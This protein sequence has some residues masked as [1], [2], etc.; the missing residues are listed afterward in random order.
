[1]AEEPTPCP[2]PTGTSNRSFAD[3]R[4]TII[5]DVVLAGV[6]AVVM[7]LLSVHFEL[8]A[9]LVSFVYANEKWELD[10]LFVVGCYSLAAAVVFF[11]RRYREMY[12]LAH[13]RDRA[14]RAVEQSQKMVRRQQKVLKKAALT[15]P[16]TG[17]PN[18]ARLMQYLEE[19]FDEDTS[20]KEFLTALLFFDFDR[21]K[22]I[23]DLHGHDVGDALLKEISRRI[24][25]R[26]Q[27]AGAAKNPTAPHFAARLGGDEF[28]AIVRNAANLEEIEGLCDELLEELSKPYSLNG[29]SVS[30]TTSIGVVVKTDAHGDASLLLGDADAAMYKAKHLGRGRVVVFERSMRDHWVR[31][32]QLDSGL[33]NALKHNELHLA[34]QPIVSLASGRIKGVEAL[35]RW[36]HP[37]LGPVNPCEFVPIAEDSD[38]I[39]EI[40]TWVLKES[41]REMAEW[42]T[43]YPCTGPDLMSI[44][45]SQRQFAEPNLVASFREIIGRSTVPANRLQLEISEDIYNGDVEANRHTIEELKQL[46]VRIAIDDFG[47]GTSMFSAIEN[48]SIDTVKIDRSLISRVAS[49]MDGAAIVHSLA[50]L[51]RNLNVTLVAGGVE[52]QQQVAV[53]QDLGCSYGQGFFFGKPMASNKIE[54][55]FAKPEFDSLTFQG[56]GNLADLWSSKLPAFQSLELEQD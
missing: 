48:F 24:Q 6:F 9:Q 52:N 46:G 42:I 2:Q 13:E 8:F 10:E 39:F 11:V 50:T 37:E 7:F 27:T 47:T 34:Y 43:R 44:N 17:L 45:L 31:R 53:L 26:I 55:M 33:H 21:F 19:V 29:I 28:V 23:N 32:V 40:G 14:L 56:V 51:V 35:L 25:G 12:L 41:L 38:L 54:A 36:T 49:S 4:K 5:L 20:D 30:T 16:L 22:Q 15:D 18:R 1:M 3:L